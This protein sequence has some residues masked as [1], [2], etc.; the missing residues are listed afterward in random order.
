MRISKM[1][2]ATMVAGAVATG[3]AA[4]GIA[5]AAT[6]PDSTDT[7]PAMPAAAGEPAPGVRRLNNAPAA[8]S[9]PMAPA[10]EEVSGRT[11]A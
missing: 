8:Q 3:G 9:S 4:A 6:P 11:A 2:G 1:L 5:G 7:S 10:G